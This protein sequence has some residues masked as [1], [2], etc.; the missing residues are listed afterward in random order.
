MKCKKS[1]FPRAKRAYQWCWTPG[2]NGSDT[3]NVV[4]CERLC[5]DILT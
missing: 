2:E 1:I 3:V 5:A 4:F